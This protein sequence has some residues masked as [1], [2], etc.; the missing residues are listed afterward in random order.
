MDFW[1]ILLD[2]LHTQGIAVFLVVT[3]TIGAAYAAHFYMKTVYPDN[4]ARVDRQY[5][6]RAAEATALAQV[7][8]GL[9]ALA[10]AIVTV[11]TRNGQGFGLAPPA[12]PGAGAS[13]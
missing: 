1:Q 8:A 4:V 10:A 5:E 12:Q 6:V 11:E 7:G 13:S 2:L 3:A 9:S